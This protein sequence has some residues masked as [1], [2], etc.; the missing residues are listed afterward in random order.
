M[1]FGGSTIRRAGKK[2][3]SSKGR[4]SKR[5]I[6]AGFLD[7]KAKLFPFFCVGAAKFKQLRLRVG[8]FHFDFIDSPLIV[9][10]RFGVNIL[11]VRNQFTNRFAPHSEL[12]LNLFNMYLHLLHQD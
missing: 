4:Q 8:V 7:I 6:V 3:L 2:L 5:E 12:K 1:A 11:D 9:N 10:P